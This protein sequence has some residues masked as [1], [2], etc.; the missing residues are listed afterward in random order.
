VEVPQSSERYT[1]LV[2]KSNQVIEA[3]KFHR[4]GN[5]LVIQDTQGRIGALPAQDVDWVKTTQ[6][7][8]ELRSVDST[9]LS[10]ETH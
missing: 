6:M 8:A 7:T 2:M 4:E 3:A 5:D 10:R 1:M 9:S